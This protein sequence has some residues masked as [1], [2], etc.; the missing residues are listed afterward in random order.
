MIATIY[1]GSG[2]RLQEIV[3]AWR[4]TSLSLKQ[5]ATHNGIHEF[6]NIKAAEIG[7]AAISTIKLSPLTLKN[8]F[9]RSSGA[10]SSAN[11]AKKSG[12]REPPPKHRKS[13]DAQ[14]RRSGRILGKK[15]TARV[16]AS[17]RKRPTS[18]R[19]KTGF[20]PMRSA[21][22]PKG[23]MRRR[24]GRVEKESLQPVSWA[25]RV[26]IAGAEIT[27]MGLTYECE[28]VLHGID[29]AVIFC[30]GVE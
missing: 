27:H 28:F 1:S 4:P 15:Q 30:C 21:R 29:F 12:E 26:S 22:A 2:I 18:V 10:K 20:L 25:G 16:N 6:L 11:M 8:A 17:A 9:A 13:E 7:P 14:M 5:H 19:M 23:I 3:S 24:A